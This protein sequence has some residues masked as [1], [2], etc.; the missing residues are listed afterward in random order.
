MNTIMTEKEQNLNVKSGLRIQKLLISSA[1]LPPVEYLALIAGADE[2][3]IEREENYLK[4][5]YRNRCYILSAHGL[6]SLTVPVYQGSIHK[7]PLKDIR[8]DYSKRWQPV[9]LGALTAA[10]SS[11]PYFQFYFENIEKILSK[12]TE[13]LLDLNSELLEAILG[14]IKIKVSVKYTDH[15]E[16]VG[17][18]ENDYRYSISPK[19][20]I[21]F[22]VRDYTH[23]FSC[24]EELSAR[25][26][27]IDLI[28]NMGPGS[29]DY[30]QIS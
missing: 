17:K 16:P 15:F 19:K 18:A 9:H 28:F 24:P 22:P 27:A 30:L 6:Q 1:Y 12:R 14:M 8:I 29:N 10:Y 26:S 2:I 21:L 5:S 25:L 20:Q 11:S 4:Q 3:L 13:F 7:T 23:V